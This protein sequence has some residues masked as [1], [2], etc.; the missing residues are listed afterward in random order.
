MPR[1]K[2]VR[3]EGL[4]DVLRHIVPPG[5]PGKQLMAACSR[6]PPRRWSEQGY[7]TIVYGMGKLR[8]A[9]GKSGAE[10]CAATPNTFKKL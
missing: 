5:C 2:K 8:L 4:P 1:K 3:R 9:A 6:Y 10:R 7:S